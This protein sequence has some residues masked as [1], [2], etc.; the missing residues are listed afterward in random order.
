MGEG[1]KSR[2]GDT[3]CLQ[4]PPDSQVGCS[5]YKSITLFSDEDKFAPRGHLPRSGDIF[6]CRDLGAGGGY[7]WH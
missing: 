6:G 1:G 2:G 7:Y 3:D 4:E 5:L